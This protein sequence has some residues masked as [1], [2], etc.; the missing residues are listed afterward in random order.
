[1]TSD[2]TTE[3]V[4]EAEP[5]ALVEAALNYEEIA[6]EVAMLEGEHADV[7]LRLEQVAAALIEARTRLAKARLA[8]T[9]L[10]GN[11]G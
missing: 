2:E 7:E 10:L 6:E 5:R 1:M 3:A 8:V 9:V 4:V 11:E